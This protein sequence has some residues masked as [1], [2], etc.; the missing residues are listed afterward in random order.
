VVQ[1]AGFNPWIDDQ[2]RAGE[3]W[4]RA[5]EAA[6][7]STCAVIVVLTPRACASDEVLSEWSFALSKG[8]AVIP[9]LALPCD[10]P[11]RLAPLQRVDWYSDPAAAAHEL[12]GRLRDLGS[13]PP[14][15]PGPSCSLLPTI[16][17]FVWRGAIT[18]P[19]AFFDRERETNTI[20]DLLSKRQNCQVV[21]PRRIGKSSLL[22]E[23]ERRAV[24]WVPGAVVAFLDLQH[25]RCETLAGWFDLAADGFGWKKAPRDRIEFADQV[26]RMVRDRKHPILLLDEFGEL[27]HRRDEYPREFFVA[28]RYFGQ[29]G[30]SIVTAAQAPL[31]DLIPADNPASPFFNIFHRLPLGPFSPADASDFLVTFGRFFSDEQRTAILT[32]ANGHPLALQIASFRVLEAAQHGDGTEVAFQAATEDM[33][34]CL[35]SWG[36]E[37]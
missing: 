11:Y 13:A 27:T 7:R 6:L 29:N 26:E 20:R 37:L 22:R 24:S 36:A 4:Q 9:V 23:V 18:E 3:N 30:L 15:E 34:T 5:I 19:A 32:F 10:P 21:G 12:T 25:P 8:I 1:A 35:P 14:V 31:S 33:R 16:N 2:L 17:P 28:L